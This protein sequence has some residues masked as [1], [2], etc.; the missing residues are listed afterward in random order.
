MPPL[1]RQ[2]RAELRKLLHPE[3]GVTVVG[4]AAFAAYLQLTNARTPYPPPSSA[5]LPGS[6]WIAADQL[7]STLGFLVGGMAAAVGTAAESASGTLELVLLHE[8]R[9]LRLVLLKIAACFGVI[10]ASVPVVAIVLRASAMGAAALGHPMTQTAGAPWSETF[11][12]WSR[13]LLV[14]AFIA[15]LATLVAVA[16]RSPLAT[17]ATTTAAFAIPLLLLSAETLRVFFPSWW[18]INWMHFDPFGFY[19]DYLASM[20]KL[21]D[22]SMPAG[23]VIALA[24]VAC[25][26]AAWRLARRPADARA[27]A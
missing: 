24:T 11:A 21:D 17:V 10:V 22:P 26:L 13:F 2:L 15:A 7:A 4:V 16:T 9:R 14:A 19:V 12:A 8:P 1:A 6:F 3:L 20:S 25:A 27:S 18:I 23:F 5:D